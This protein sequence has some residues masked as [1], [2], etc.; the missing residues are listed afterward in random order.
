MEPLIVCQKCLGDLYRSGTKAVCVEC[1]TSFDV[2]NKVYYF[3][4]VDHSPKIKK[5]LR[6]LRNWSSW[7]KQNFEYLQKNLKGLIP[8]SYVLDLGAGQGNFKNTFE[9]CHYVAVDFYPYEDVQVVSDITKQLPFRSNMFDFILLSNVLEHVKEPKSLL[10]ECYRVLKPQGT[11]ILLVP[12]IIRLHQIPYDF[13][14]YTHYMLDYLL[15][16][17]GFIEREI[18]KIG[19]IFDV[20]QVVIK[21]CFLVYLNNLR[22]QIPNRYIRIFPQIVLKIIWGAVLAL[23]F[24]SKKIFNND[25]TI[26]KGAESPQGYGCVARK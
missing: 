2:Q 7:R 12:F 6:D 19:T 9:N 3:T 13:L 17:S 1:K 25:T 23:L 4:S 26:Q 18:K 14:R 15:E 5:G 22:Q 10:K 21:G 24:V 16:Q 11:L 8:D 20:Q